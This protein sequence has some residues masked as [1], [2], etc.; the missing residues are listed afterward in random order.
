VRALFQTSTGDDG[1]HEPRLFVYDDENVK[2]T[3]VPG[4]G[5]NII[6]AS[7]KINSQRLLVAAV[8]GFTSRQDSR[9]TPQEQAFTRLESGSGKRRRSRQ[10]ARDR[11]VS[12]RDV[13]RDLRTR[14]RTMDGGAQV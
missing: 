2:W 12:R 9:Q 8:S 13:L 5:A 14:H 7:R 6:Y 4:L 3:N 10:R 1:R 11:P